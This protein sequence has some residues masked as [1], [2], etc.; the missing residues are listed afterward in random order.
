MTEAPQLVIQPLFAGARDL[1]PH[2]C[3][4]KPGEQAAACQ[5]KLEWKLQ[6]ISRVSQ[7]YDI[8]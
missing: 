2:S 5:H 4:T 3:A 1:E 6:H 8:C 7:S